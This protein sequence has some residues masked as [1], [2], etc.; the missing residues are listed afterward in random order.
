MCSITRTN[1][2]MIPATKAYWLACLECELAGV[3]KQFAQTM[4]FSPGRPK[5]LVYRDILG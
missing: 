3:A 2:G 4:L 1:P 5:W